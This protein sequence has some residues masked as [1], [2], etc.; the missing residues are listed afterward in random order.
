MFF[1]SKRLG[2]EFFN[3]DS[4]ATVEE[5]RLIFTPDNAIFKNLM[6]QVSKMLSLE[7]PIGVM[8]RKELETTM[9]ER[10]MLAGIEFHHSEVR[11]K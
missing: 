9:H 6:E 7:H 5:R 8:N 4:T 3:N 10:K 11:F 1:K 2:D